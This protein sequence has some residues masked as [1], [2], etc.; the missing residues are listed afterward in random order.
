MTIFWI[1]YR[2]ALA[3][4]RARAHLIFR[5]PTKIELSVYADAAC[6]NIHTALSAPC[7]R[8]GLNSLFSSSFLFTF[9]SLH[10]SLFLSFHFVVKSIW[11][12]TVQPIQQRQPQTHE[13]TAAK[14]MDKGE[15]WNW[16]FSCLL[17]LFPSQR[18]HNTFQF[19]HILDIL[20]SHLLCYL[21]AIG[22]GWVIWL[23]HLIE[24]PIYQRRPQMA[25]PL[26]YVIFPNPALAMYNEI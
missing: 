22:Q 5:V 6:T 25:A 7:T 13:N 4:E 16:V 21:P 26:I 3:C 24:L 15:D 9:L 11:T 14:Q 10:L 1:Y 23:L 12:A 2:F 19:L 20:I 8:G 17:I 18:T